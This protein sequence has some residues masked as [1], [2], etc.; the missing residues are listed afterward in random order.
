MLVAVAFVSHPSYLPVA[1]DQLLCLLQAVVGVA[2][3]HICT[4]AFS[5]AQAEGAASLK[6]RCS[7]NKEQEQK[8]Q[9]QT[10]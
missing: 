6:T 1:A 5:R 10:M 9:N 7:L 8:Q 2:G 4:P 3:V